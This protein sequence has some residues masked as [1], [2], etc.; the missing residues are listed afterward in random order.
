MSDALVD[1]MTITIYALGCN[2]IIGMYNLECCGYFDTIEI[3]LPHQTLHEHAIVV[4]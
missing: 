4:T 3:N 2:I 1:D